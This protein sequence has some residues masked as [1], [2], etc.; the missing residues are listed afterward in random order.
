MG[1]ISNKIFMF[2]NCSIKLIYKFSYTLIDL[3]CRKLQIQCSW[4]INITY[5]ALD[6]F[7]NI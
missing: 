7:Y 2:P 5:R 1:Y 3:F 4:P 6:D